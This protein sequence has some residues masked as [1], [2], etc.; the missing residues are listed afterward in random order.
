MHYDHTPLFD[1]LQYFGQTVLKLQKVV[2][3]L[4]FSPYTTDRKAQKEENL[5][6]N[7]YYYP[8]SNENLS[9]TVDSI[10]VAENCGLAAAVSWCK[11]IRLDNLLNKMQQIDLRKANALS[12]L[13]TL[14]RSVENLLE[15]NR[16]GD[17]G[18]HGFIGERAQVY[19]TNAWALINGEVK[20]SVLIDDNGMVD[21]IERGI[22]IQ[23]KACRANGFLGLD[24][25]MDHKAKYPTFNGKY[26]IPKDFY[27]EFHRLA[28]M[29][30]IDAGKLSRHEWNLWQEVQRI[31][32]AN[33]E[34][35]PMKVTYEEIQRDNI[36]GTINRQKEQ[37]QKTHN[38]NAQSVVNEHKPTVKACLGTTAASSVIE[39]TLSGA[40]VIIDK[41]INGKSIKDY[42]KQDVKDVGLATA[43]GSVRGAIRGAAVY[44]VENCTPVP[45]IIAGGAVTVAWDG[46]KAAY[47]YNKGLA[48]K[49][50][51]IDIVVRSLVKATAGTTG[52]LIGG[53]I[54]PIPVVGEVIGG[55]AFSLVSDKLY[56]YLKNKK[57]YAIF[58]TKLQSS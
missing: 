30:K 22:N 55:F 31:K 53:Q 14:A 29:E 23:Q 41:K 45:G 48:T 2:D 57:K 40:A 21:Y 37:I 52:A 27:E 56:N 28:D 9:N 17:K 46:A 12:E 26:Q 1:F 7:T 42:D 50:E 43:E 24:H 51:C 25:I 8:N 20:P 11:T 13:E 19:I 3:I 38:K 16:G 10:K 5:M 44:I 47:K 32:N 58:N 4:Y 49:E 34:V 6:I 18:I 39:G 15:S 35:E 33:I 36:F 54:C